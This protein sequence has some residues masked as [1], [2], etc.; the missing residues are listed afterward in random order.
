MFQSILLKPWVSLLTV[1]S[2]VNHLM[3]KF[4]PFDRKQWRSF[5]HM[6]LRVE[7]VCRAVMYFDY[8]ADDIC[9]IEE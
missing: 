5:L 4:D 2:I 9:Q 6:D 8:G 1:F 3:I 7:G